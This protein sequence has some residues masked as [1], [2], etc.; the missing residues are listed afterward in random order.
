MPHVWRQFAGQRRIHGKVRTD[1]QTPEGYR[2][3]ATSSTPDR[4]SKLA[5]EPP[6]DCA[7][8]LKP[9]FRKKKRRRSMISR[10]PLVEFVHVVRASAKPLGRSEHSSLPARAAVLSLR[11]RFPENRWFCCLPAVLL[12]QELEVVALLLETRVIAPKNHAQDA[13]GAPVGILGQL[14]HMSSEL[15][16]SMREKGKYCAGV[17]RSARDVVGRVVG[18]DY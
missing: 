13:L 9:P 16:V 14:R 18:I 10:M 8:S 11:R 7:R 15:F 6:L 5:V 3:A 17:A 12:G 4:R 2:D 1:I